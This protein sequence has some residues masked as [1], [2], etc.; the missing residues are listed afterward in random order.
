MERDCFMLSPD[1]TVLGTTVTKKKKES[2]LLTS[3]GERKQGQEGSPVHHCPIPPKFRKQIPEIPF[4]LSYQI[5]R[6]YFKIMQSYNKKL[7]YTRFRPREPSHR[8]DNG[9]S[10]R[11]RRGV[12]Q[13]Y[14][15]HSMG[16]NGRTG[17]SK[18]SMR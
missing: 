12:L 1:G 14:I 6:F 16:W 9:Q 4:S 7:S 2:C 3:Y 11:E 13:L 18:G 15:L 5:P 17:V 8:Q 10:G